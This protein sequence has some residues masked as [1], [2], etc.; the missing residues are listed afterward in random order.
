[1]IATTLK[2]KI[3]VET[4]GL[5]YD[6]WL[7]YR[8]LGI[9]G[10]DIAAICGLSKWK[11]AVHVYME[12]LGQNKDELMSEAAEWG[13]RLEPV[14]AKKFANNHP[15]WAITEKKVIYCHPKHDWALGNLDGMIIDPDQGR[16]ILE[17]KTANEYL[18]H[19]WDDGNIPDYYF[20]QLQWYM[21]VT[22]LQ[23]GYFG[24]LIG[25]NKYREYPVQ[26]DDELIMQLFRLASDFWHNHVLLEN[27]PPVDG[28]D[29]SVTLLNQMYP[30]AKDGEVVELQMTD[31]I[32]SY[33]DKK[34][35]MKDLEEEMK[36]TE[37]LIKSQLGN[38]ELGASGPYKIKWENRTRNG[39]DSKKLKEEFPEV[40]QDCA[41][42]TLFRQFSI[43][44]A[45]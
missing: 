11:T 21:F 14:I 5:S 37:N 30:S 19:A 44:E 35:L 1:M 20:V 23:W 31:Q 41:K 45:H 40:Y 4:E 25:G 28:S 7:N 36:L 3:L 43:K 38:H 10:S 39:V 33:L 32:K 2:A 27:S 42:Q 17:I 29:A 16:G 24:T 13:T 26:R 22:D 6:E 9:G 34:L 12:K 8:R 18:K 15:E